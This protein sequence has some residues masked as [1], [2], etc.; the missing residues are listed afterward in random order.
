MMMVR[1]SDAHLQADS[2]RAL[3]SDG[4]E[5]E[6]DGGNGGDAITEDVVGGRGAADRADMRGP[7]GYPWGWNPAG[8]H[9]SVEIE[10]AMLVRR[11]G[12]FP[13]GD[14]LRDRLVEY[15]AALR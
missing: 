7:A 9:D 12:A 4:N 6:G 13:W 14:R 1:I 8:P 10:E 2:Q 5:G 11:R 15:L 3:R